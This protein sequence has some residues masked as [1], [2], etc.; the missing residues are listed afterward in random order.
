MSECL[1]VISACLI[2]NLIIFI[3]LYDG[4]EYIA[5]PV[6]SNQ[7]GFVTDNTFQSNGYGLVTELQVLNPVLFGCT[8]TDYFEYNPQ[9]NLDDGTCLI[10][11]SFG[12]TNPLAD[13]YNED[14][15]IN[16]ISFDDSPCGSSRALCSCKWCCTQD[17]EKFCDSW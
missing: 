12:C 11:A 13:N 8:N 14:A 9:A 16:Q 7:T 5:N 17:K 2:P 3:V 10:L 6:F 4:I 1:I 15:N